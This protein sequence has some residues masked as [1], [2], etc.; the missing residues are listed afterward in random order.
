[1]QIKVCGLTRD[2]DVQLC[3]QLGVDWMGFIFHPASPRHVTAQQVAAFET[4][5]ARRVGVFVTHS[6]E[7]INAM[8]K[9]ARLNLVQLHG[10]YL[11][12]DCHK[13]FGAQKIKVFWP[14]RHSARTDFQATLA[15]YVSACDYF[16]LDAGSAGGGHSRTLQQ[17]WLSD[18]ISPRPWILAGG[19]SP[20]NICAML[21]QYHPQGI[22]LNSGVESAPGVKDHRLLGKLVEVVSS[23]RP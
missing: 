2:A 12:E 5:A 11:P 3:R 10:D 20:D 6:I 21:Q 16:L 4:G 9:T 17:S 13:I 22:D 15:P 18:F 23:T 1:M 8:I 14:E 7:Q 19:L